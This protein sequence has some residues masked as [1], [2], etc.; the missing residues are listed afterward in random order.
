MRIY[1]ELQVRRELLRIGNEKKYEK[2]EK[3]DQE[4]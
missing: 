3:K 1:A 4:M 2:R